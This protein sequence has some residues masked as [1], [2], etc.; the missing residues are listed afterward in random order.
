M[1]DGGVTPSYRNG[2]V[3]AESVWN[4]SLI[5]ADCSLPHCSLPVR[6]VADALAH[7]LLGVVDDHKCVRVNLADHILN[8]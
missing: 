5:T 4:K 8:P 7:D 6:L 1:S 2:Y 3:P